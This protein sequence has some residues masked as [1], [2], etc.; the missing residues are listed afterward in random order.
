M[1]RIR[2]AIATFGG[3]T[4]V[5]N[6]TLEGFVA[7]AQL[8][9][10]AVGVY[11]GPDGFVTGKL[12][13][14]GERSGFGAVEACR[15]GSWLGAGRHFLTDEAIDAGLKHLVAQGVR[16]LAVVGGNGTMTC[17]QQLS[18]RAGDTGLPLAVV[19]LPK[20]IDNDLCG[21]DHSP[22]FGSAAT[23]VA[24]MVADLA[25]DHRAMRSI[26][27]VRIVET[28]GRNSGWLALSSLLARRTTNSEPHLVYVPE[29]HFDE[30]QFL[31]EVHEQVSTTGGAFVVVAEGAASNLVDDRFERTS[32]DR[33]IEGGV[34]R[35]LA[36][37]VRDVLGLTTRAEIP[38]LVQRCSSRHVS[39]R[40]RLEAFAVGREGARLLVSGQTGVMVSLVPQLRAGISNEAMEEERPAV[41]RQDST[42]EV[43]EVALGTV[44]LAEVAGRTRRLPPGWV[45]PSPAGDSP[46]F[47]AWLWKVLGTGLATQAFHDRVSAAGEGGDEEYAGETPFAGS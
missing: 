17:C 22:G 38:G 31:A 37:R 32:F 24:E 42:W 46:H 25:F 9:G 44:K 11:G 19:G 10:D 41:S 21:T 18:E 47:E 23:F 6:A 33:P 16:G 35:V 13:D 1:S 29:R 45:P 20:T 8:H 34:A 27:Q 4:A 2:L 28:L 26:E 3:P 15:P 36:E 39:P 12:C 14:L 40:D 5:L 43:T 7:E 30:G